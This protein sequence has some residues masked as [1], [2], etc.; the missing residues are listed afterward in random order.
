M[1]AEKQILSPLVAG[2]LSGLL[3]AGL[4]IFYLWNR[5]IGNTQLEFVDLFDFVWTYGLIDTDSKC[6]IDIN[7]RLR[8][9][10]TVMKIPVAKWHLI[11]IAVS[12][13]IGGLIAFLYQLR[14][15]PLR[16]LA[17]TIQG[18]R[19]L[20]DADGR[21]SIRAKLK[22]G[23][24]ADTTSLWLMPYVQLTRTAE[25]FYTI[26]LG[27]HGSGKTGILRGW[28]EQILKR[29]YRLIIHCAKGDLTADLP[30]DNF[31]LSAI[32]D[33]RSW[34]WEPGR[35][36]RNGQDAA[37]FST[38][39]IQ[40]STSGESI[41]PDSARRVLTG[42]I[43]SLRKQH[44]ADWSWEDLN[45]QI[46]QSARDIKKVLDQNGCPDACLITEAEDGQINR[47]TQSIL[48]TMWISALTTILP[49]VE[50]SRR[51]PKSRRF[52]ISEWLSMDS[53][54]PGKL[55]LQ[56][57]S[58]HPNLSTAINGLIVE[59]VAGKILSP[60]MPKRSSPWLYMILDELPVLKKL[61]R[62]PELLNVGREKGVR[63]IAAAQDWEQVIKNYGNEDAATLEARFKI[64][65]VCQ[66]GISETRDR[67]VE[68]Y[69]GSR[70]IVEW[71][72]GIKD[73]P[74]TRRESK[75]SVIQAHQLSDDL[76]VRKLNG[77]LQVRTAIF[78]LGP[79][80]IA[81]IPFTSWVERRPPHIPVRMVSGKKRQ[82]NRHKPIS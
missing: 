15:T 72:R 39:F 36:I 59:I 21:R 6:G 80:V 68:K 81:N 66:L 10:A 18:T 55:V 37:E 1:R 56:N 32:N 41:W 67:V 45:N 7:C 51:T 44:G 46:F 57:S 62:L 65:V 40:S 34:C 79:P 50:L 24:K 63:C 78:G 27:D 49:F 26:L 29:D 70:T 42:L 52:S 17:Q 76:G 9:M 28:L 47:T 74:P 31:I 14:H 22:H 33:G 64:K 38:K 30:D 23:G 43:E 20:Y 75:I 5:D 25:S 12:S 69:A 19:L 4:S 16:E 35:D 13:T 8:N 54:L 48:L 73:H 61:H 82:I 11:A 53:T 77:Q 58:E 60:T 3:I 71:D 2:F